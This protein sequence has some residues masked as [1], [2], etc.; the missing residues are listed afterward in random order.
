MA[1]F[2]SFEWPQESTEASCG[3]A[4]LCNP[5]TREAEGG[6]SQVQ[7]QPGLLLFLGPQDYIYILYIYIYIFY[8]HISIYTRIYTYI[9]I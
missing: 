3:G 1:P 4:H 8:T 9:H 5:S 7:D 2:L 6:E